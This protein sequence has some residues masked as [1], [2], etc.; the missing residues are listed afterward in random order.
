[1]SYLERFIGK[2]Y[3][4]NKYKKPSSIIKGQVFQLNFDNG[5]IDQQL[6]NMYTIINLN[7][8]QLGRR[9]CP[10]CIETIRENKIPEP[11]CKQCKSTDFY[12][13]LG[14][15]RAEYVKEFI[16]DDFY[17]LSTKVIMESNPTDLICLNQLKVLIGRCNWGE[18]IPTRPLNINPPHYLL[19]YKKQIVASATYFDNTKIA[20]LTQLIHM[21][22]GELGYVCVDPM[23][24]S[25]GYFDYMF[26]YALDNLHNKKIWLWTSELEKSLLY[27]S[28]GFEYIRN[29]S[30]GKRN[31]IQIIN[32]INHYHMKYRPNRLLSESYLIR[33]LFEIVNNGI[34]RIYNLSVPSQNTEGNLGLCG[35]YTPINILL[36]FEACKGSNPTFENN[37]L[38]VDW[39]IKLL[40]NNNIYNGLSQVNGYNDNIIRLSNEVYREYNLP[41]VWF[42]RGINDNLPIYMHP[43]ASDDIKYFGT[44]NRRGLIPSE[45]L[46]DNINLNIDFL[47]NSTILLYGSNKSDFNNDLALYEMIIGLDIN[48]DINEYTNENINEHI[49]EQ[50]INQNFRIM[51]NFYESHNYVF[52]IQIAYGSDHW[53]SAVINKVNDIV[54]IYFMDSLNKSITIYN[55][56]SSLLQKLVTLGSFK[57]FL[58][59]LLN[60]I[61]SNIEEKYRKCIENIPIRITDNFGNPAQIMRTIMAEFQVN[62]DYIIRHMKFIINK[63]HWIYAD[64]LYDFVDWITKKEYQNEYP[65]GGEDLINFE[66]VLSATN[67]MSVDEFLSS[68]FD[69]NDCLNENN[70]LKMINE[71]CELRHQ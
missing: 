38:L 41:T 1:M 44:F 43:N 15:K 69:I 8:R 26:R 61:K 50:L 16:D 27:Y 14:Q 55:T 37:R 34:L 5:D 24:R 21:L 20:E 54:E 67:N 53:V 12:E 10:S 59:A 62:R 52:A 28:H 6:R 70:I 51:K 13:L 47:I 23:Y 40:K 3:E 4:Y 11:D 65:I 9:Y 68:F 39:Y 25:K 32:N 33:H 58:N 17:K 22:D 46:V 18:H 29:P 19:L 57:N 45:S 30:Y 31:G 56:L 63:K 36:C 7:I 64:D 66:T 71:N 2:S 35:V 49:N 48:K 60:S 42:Y